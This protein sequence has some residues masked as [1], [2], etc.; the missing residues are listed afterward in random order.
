[1]TFGIGLLVLTAALL[2]ALWNA[3]V[4]GA[5]D[6]TVMLGCIALGHVIPGVVMVAISPL[7]APASIPFMVASV[8]VHWVYFFL[9][10]T[11]YRLGDLSLIYPV[12]RGLAPVLVALGAQYWAGETLSLPAWIGI[13]AVSA[14]IMV[15]SSSAIKGSVPML[16]LLAAVI[17]GFIVATYTLVDGI[18]VRKSGHAISY[19]GWL[20]TAKILI[21]LYVFPTR[22]GRVRAIPRKVLMMGMLGG[23]VSGFAYALVLYAK[24]VAPLGLVSAL[25]ETSVIFAALI[26]VIW[27][28]EG[29]RLQRL[30]AAAIVAAGIATLAVSR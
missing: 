28:R 25:R 3:L 11:A 7:P 30:F 20:F 9:L 19:I 22:M 18:G 15:I 27:F 26:G 10:N 23:L 13:L 17:I 24:T 14:G 4:K 2:H 5:E 1:M 6:K 12:S 16:A 29:P 21:V 8:T